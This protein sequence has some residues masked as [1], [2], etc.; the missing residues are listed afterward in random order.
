MR[1]VVVGVD[2]VWNNGVD[3][4]TRLEGH[5]SNGSGHSQKAPLLAKDA[6][7]GAPALTETDSR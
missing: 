3:N 4:I 2:L 5:Q 7:N 6:R 1:H